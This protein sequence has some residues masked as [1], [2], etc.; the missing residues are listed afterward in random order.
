MLVEEGLRPAALFNATLD[1]RLGHLFLANP[2]LLSLAH[3]RKTER[4]RTWLA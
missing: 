2:L 3:E 1:I 4:G